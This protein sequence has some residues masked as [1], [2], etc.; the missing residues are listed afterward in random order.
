MAAIVIVLLVTILCVAHF[1][2]KSDVLTSFTTTIVAILATIIAFNFFEVLG[3]LMLQ[4]N[5]MPVRAAGVSFLVLFGLSFAILSILVKLVVGSKIAYPNAAKIA[6]A[7]VCGTITGLIIS[8]CI[9]VAL[10]TSAI[11]S[12]LS[13]KRFDGTLTSNAIANPKKS[14]LGT[15]DMVTNLF[16]WISSGSMSGKRNFKLYHADF[17]NQIHLNKHL[18]ADNV[19]PISGSDAVS[20]PKLGV[21]NKKDLEGDTYTL[22]R[23]EMKGTKI[24][25]GGITNEAGDMGFGMFH[26][27]LICTRSANQDV[28]ILYPKSIGILENSRVTRRIKDLGEAIY[29]DRDKLTSGKLGIVDLEFNI[30]SGFE[31]KLLEFKNIAVIQVPP[32]TSDEEAEDKINAVFKKT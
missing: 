5:F 14:F 28:K 9:L 24:D 32:V 27:R 26:I 31:P 21:R 29:I 23:L 30:P 12:K 19:L 13:Y 20:I 8:G 18:M 2:L 6:V 3:G 7:L 25:K 17:I 16:G 22:V 4:K 10:G 11:P 15:D 1:Y